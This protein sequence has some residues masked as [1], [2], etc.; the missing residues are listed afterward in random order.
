MEAATAPDAPRERRP[1]RPRDPRV[2]NAI[3]RATEE[4]LVQVGYGALSIERIAARAGV[5]KPTIYRRW[6]NKAL[7]VWDAVLGKTTRRALPD[8]G[9]VHDDIREVLRMGVEQITAPAARAAL[10]GML[11]ELG[12]DPELD[13]QIR[14]ALIDPEYA[15]VRTV[16]HQARERGELRPDANLDL[17]M[18]AL[19][20]TV[21]GRALLLAHPLDDDFISALTDLLLT[22][23]GAKP[24]Q[25]R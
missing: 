11:M 14:A 22:G 13:D 9:A 15:R 7:L 3:L 8:T 16:L 1:G 4:L 12:A 5:G 24:R 23:A 17:I 18:D 2:Q 10:P 20:G 6:P 21:L 19:V 25:T